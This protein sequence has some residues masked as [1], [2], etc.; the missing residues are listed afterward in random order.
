MEFLSFPSTLIV[1]ILALSLH[2][3]EFLSYPLKHWNSGPIFVHIDIIFVLILQNIAT[4]A[5]SLY[6]LKSLSYPSEHWK[7]GLILLHIGILISSFQTLEFW[8]FLQTL[9][10]LSNPSTANWNSGLI[11]P[12]TGI[13]SHYLYTL[14][15]W[16]YPSKHQILSYFWP[17]SYKHWNS[18]PILID[19]GILIPSFSTANIGILALFL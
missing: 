18:G 1:G 17:S 2:T 6:P 13:F 4:L 15:F 9:D 14:G 7:S 3:L 10:F 5:L 19:I 11:L 8:P 12:N 16:S